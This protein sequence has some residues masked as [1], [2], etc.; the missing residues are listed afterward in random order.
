[1]IFIL[2]FC[3][4]FSD[5][6]HKCRKFHCI[7]FPAKWCQKI[8]EETYFVITFLWQTKYFV[9][10]WGY[11]WQI[12]CLSKIFL[13]W[14]LIFLVVIGQSPSLIMW[15]P[16]SIPTHGRTFKQACQRKILTLFWTQRDQTCLDQLQALLP[17]VSRNWKPTLPTRET[18]TKLLQPCSHREETFFVIEPSKLIFLLLTTHH[19]GLTCL[20][21]TRTNMSL[22]QVHIP[23]SI[24]S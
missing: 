23:R 7:Y 20:R 8:L 21:F 18:W 15:R 10:N 16:A 4:S 13:S 2:I 17:L 24:R 19:Y 12:W 3:F 14:I 11:L 22:Q 5:K 9:R 1:M 6:C